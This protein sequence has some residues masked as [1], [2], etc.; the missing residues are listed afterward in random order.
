MRQHSVLSSMGA[1]KSMALLSSR[2]SEISRP[3]VRPILLQEHISQ[4]DEDETW[5]SWLFAPKP[6]RMDNVFTY[7][8][9]SLVSVSVYLA[10]M[11]TAAYFYDKY[12]EPRKVPP[13]D[14]L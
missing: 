6:Q 10:L 9:Q 3:Y 1:P 8:W 2:I 7:W 12:K 11:G 13:A 5:T 14:T 4:T